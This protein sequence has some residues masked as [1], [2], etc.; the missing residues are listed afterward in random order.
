MHTSSTGSICFFIIV[1]FLLM[2][3]NSLYIRNSHDPIASISPMSTGL[4]GSAENK[5]R[6]PKRGIE[7]EQ[8]FIFWGR[9]INLIGN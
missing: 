7:Q 5:I 2:V 6:I 4:W 9:E 8:G 3:V 1:L